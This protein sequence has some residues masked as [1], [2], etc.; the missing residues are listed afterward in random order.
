M[1]DY[2]YLLK[3][4]IYHKMNSNWISVFLCIEMKKENYF[5]FPFQTRIFIIFNF[6]H[7]FVN[8]CSQKKI[9]DIK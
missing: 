7:L 6:L 8:N 1:L 4:L 3:L 5:S 9:N 2:E